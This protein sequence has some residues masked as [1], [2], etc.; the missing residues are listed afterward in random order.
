MQRHWNT[1]GTDRGYENLI[2]RTTELSVSGWGLRV[3]N[4]ETFIAGKEEVNHERDNAF[5]AILKRNLKE[6]SKRQA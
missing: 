4:L 3:L 6:K 5:I 1:Y 2:E